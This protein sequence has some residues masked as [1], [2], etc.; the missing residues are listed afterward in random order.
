VLL[1]SVS[2]NAL[3]IANELLN[4]ASSSSLRPADDTRNAAVLTVKSLLDR[5]LE[6][7]DRERTMFIAAQVI[8]DF[9]ELWQNPFGYINTVCPGNG[10][11]W[12]LGA[13]QRGL[14][15]TER[16]HEITTDTMI[17]G[18]IV[19]LLQQRSSLEMTCLGCYIDDDGRVRNKLND[20][21]ICAHD[22]EHMSCKGAIRINRTF[23]AY[24]ISRRISPAQPSFHPVRYNPG[25]P[26][27]IYDIARAA[28]KAYITLV[29][30]ERWPLLHDIFLT[31]IE[32]KIGT[33]WHQIQY[34]CAIL[35]TSRKE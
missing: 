17:C 3:Y 20:H 28:I 24:Q 5:T 18:N 29:E 33:T 9:E 27:A 22:G 19:S 10:A 30:V 13:Y 1:R 34:V 8:S 2:E 7:T 23:A 35:Q 14:P 31:N 32:K 16:K 26:P 15:A 25:W 11:A 6:Q 12:F 21:L 4:L